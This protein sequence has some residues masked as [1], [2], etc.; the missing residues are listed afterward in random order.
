MNVVAADFDND[1]DVDLFVLASGDIGQQENLLLLNDGKGHFTRR[2]GRRRRGGQ[3][4]PAWA[5]RSTTADVDGD[6]FLDLFSPTAAAWAAAWACR[7]T[8]GGYQLFR[9]VANNGNHW[10]MI[11]LEGTRPTATASAP[12]CG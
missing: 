8:A 2:Q 9:N 11:D 5:T 4:R 10:L 12:W 7:R 6:G 1:M 3:H